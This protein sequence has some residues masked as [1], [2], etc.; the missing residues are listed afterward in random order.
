VI[1][2][3]TPASPAGNFGNAVTA[4]RWA[5]ML[6]DLGHEVRIDQRYQGGDY[7]A[8]LAMHARKSA[9][10]VLRF[11]ADH[12]HTPVVLALTGTDLYPDLATT[13][14]NPAV[15]ATADRLI[16]LQPLALAQLPAA[17]HGRTRVVT[18]SVPAIPPRPRRTDCFE[19]V[20]LAHLRAVKDPLLAARAVRQLPGSSRIH[21]THAGA[22]HDENSAAEA[23]VEA[24][25]NP[26]Y[27]WV[28]SLAREEALELLARARVLLC[29]SRHEGGANVVSEAIA[30]GVPVIG[31]AI[32]GNAGLLGDDYPGLFPAGDADALADALLAAEQNR[33]G[34]HQTLRRRCAALRPLVNPATER[35]KLRQLLAEL[36]L[37]VPI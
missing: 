34:Y 2:L 7:T 5:N 19:V 37:P 10:A 32:P 13:G 12:P 16:V 15:L 33:D 20:L 30:A 18:Q 11:R 3:V 1:L 6:R 27:D 9:D 36:Q 29:T 25:R 8:L 35:E 23:T 26:R 4:R 21:V 17:L 31:S 22:A 24:A 28:G 14:V